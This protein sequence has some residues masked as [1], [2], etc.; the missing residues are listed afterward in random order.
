MG[1]QP[2]SEPAARGSYLDGPAATL[3]QR[4]GSNDDVLV[5]EDETMV[6]IS[7]ASS[8]ASNRGRSLR[9]QN[10]NVSRIFL[11]RTRTATT[12]TSTRQTRRSSLWCRVQNL[13]NRIYR[14]TRRINMIDNPATQN[15]TPTSSSSSSPAP[16]TRRSLFGDPVTRPASS[17]RRSGI[18]GPSS[19][20]PVITRPRPVSLAGPDA[21]IHNIDPRFEPSSNEHRPRT[22][23]TQIESRHRSSSQRR[24]IWG[25]SSSSSSRPITANL[26]LC[27]NGASCS[28]VVPRPRLFRCS[29]EDEDDYDLQS[30]ANA[31]L[32]A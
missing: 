7:S 4:A 9:Q 20:P 5:S 6:D 17:R 2:S 24:S 3:R 16:L 14:T 27:R 22:S 29:C 8:L 31:A 11:Q 30:L 26:W 12:T 21:F 28:S 15:I 25:V 19:A 1:Q 10:Q 32:K 23:H 13:R 18:F